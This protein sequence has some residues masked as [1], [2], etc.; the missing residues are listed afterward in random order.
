M[1]IYMYLYM[2]TSVRHYEKSIIERA[3]DYVNDRTEN[4]DNYY[5]C[6]RRN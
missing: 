2:H 5:P 6:R 3:T 4:F 1:H